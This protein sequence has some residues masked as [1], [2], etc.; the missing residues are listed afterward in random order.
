MRGSAALCGSD[1]I[2]F[3]ER[4]RATKF[5]PTSAASGHRRN[6]LLLADW[7]T[8]RRGRPQGL[9]KL[10]EAEVKNLPAADTQA[11]AARRLTR[12]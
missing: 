10:T 9:N 3:D 8:T 1:G 6:T 7:P 5:K 2:H 12:D 4:L 11:T